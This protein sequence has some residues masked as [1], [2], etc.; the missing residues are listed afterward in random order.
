MSLATH[1][2]RQSF[3]AD[4]GALGLP[5]WR[6]YAGGLW[7]E[8][9][10]LHE[11]SGDPNAVHMDKPGWLDTSY[12]LFQVEGRTA[13]GLLPGL[14]DPAPLFRPILNR[15]LALSVLESGIRLYTDN[16]MDAVI[17]YYNGGSWGATRKADGTLY[18]QV[19]VDAV[20]AACERIKADRNA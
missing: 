20:L 3:D 5:S 15:A 9:L 12:G 4:A 19:Y 18:D 14:I 2:W 8:A 17:A 16:D 11:S 10:C 7:L 6:G 1:Q 13:Q